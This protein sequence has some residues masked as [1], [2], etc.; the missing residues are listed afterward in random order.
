MILS[1]RFKWGKGSSGRILGD[2]DTKD[3]ERDDF[4][5][6]NHVSAI[7]EIYKN[8]FQF[9]ILQICLIIMI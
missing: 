4:R 5:N 7:Q 3:P 1:E 9:Y 2:I 6:S 8:G